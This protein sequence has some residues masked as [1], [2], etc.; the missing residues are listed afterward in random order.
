MEFGIDDSFRS[1]VIQKMLIEK[2]KKKAKSLLDSYEKALTE[3]VERCEREISLDMMM[4]V[5][6]CMSIQWS[7]MKV[8]VF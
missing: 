4:H 5:N 3:V 1:R 8:E 2:K 6:K 7:Q